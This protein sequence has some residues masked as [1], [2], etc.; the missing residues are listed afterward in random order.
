M[1]KTVSFNPSDF[2]ETKLGIQEGKIEISKVFATTHQFPVSKKTGDQSDPFVC[3]AMEVVRCDDNWD[4]VPEETDTWYLGVG[5]SNKDGTFKF[6]PATKEGPDD[7]DAEDLGTDEL[8]T[9]GNCIIAPGDHELD[10]RS[11]WAMVATSLLDAGFKPEILGRGYLPDLVGLKA[12]VKKGQMGKGDGGEERTYPQFV[13]LITAK[14]KATGKNTG[15]PAAKDTKETKET[16]SDPGDQALV[17]L[18]MVKEKLGE[19]KFPADKV[20]Q[21]AQTMLI[22]NA[23]DY[24]SKTHK[25]ILG[26]LKDEDFLSAS[27]EALEIGDYDS[28]KK[29]V[30]FS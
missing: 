15:K 5:G 11:K 14:T 30:N 28:K 7:D 12:E 29:V 21:M 19:G 3:V 23:K 2:T 10:K 13:K 6:H 4:E 17:I 27:I 18:G 25:S 8:D 24:P 22:K 1:A 26:Q 20:F 16:E 9:E